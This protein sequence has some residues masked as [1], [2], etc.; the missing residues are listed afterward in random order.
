MQ[1]LGNTKNSTTLGIELLRT[2]LETYITTMKKA[3]KSPSCQE[4]KLLGMM[5]ETIEFK[6]IRMERYIVLI[7][8]AMNLLKIKMVTLS[9]SIKMD[10]ESSETYMEG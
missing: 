2:T 1:K 3:I 6:K 5:R 7:R 10:I 9:L 8:M 4:I